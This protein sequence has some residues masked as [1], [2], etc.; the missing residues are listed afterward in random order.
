MSPFAASGSL[1]QLSR[2]GV[3]VAVPVAVALRDTIRGRPAP[4]RADFGIGVRRQRG[5]DHGRQQI[6]HR[7]RRCVGQGLAQQAGRLD[8]MR[9]GHR[10]DAF[11]VGCENFLGGSHSDRVYV[12]DEPATMRYT[13]LRDSTSRFSARGS[14][15]G[16]LCAHSPSITPFGHLVSG[17]RS[18]SCKG[19]RMTDW[20]LMIRESRTIENR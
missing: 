9:S 1:I 11:R 6:A 12:R 3:E 18:F 15:H 10:S 17:I 2:P 5:G 19:S 20:R 16:P 13:T 7:I 8:N 4:F 14:G